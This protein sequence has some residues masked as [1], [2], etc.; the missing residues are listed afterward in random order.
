MAKREKLDESAIAALL[1]SRPGW[2]LEGNALVREVAFESYGEGIAFVVALGFA[3]EKRDHHPMLKVGYAK[4][5][6]RWTTDDRGG[7]TDVDFEMAETT[8]RLAKGAR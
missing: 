4:V 5:E 2:R 1:R 6:V 3:A 7:V 8:D